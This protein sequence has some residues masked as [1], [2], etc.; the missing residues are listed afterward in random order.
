VTISRGRRGIRIF[1]PDKEQLRENVIR[2]GDQ[3]LALDLVASRVRELL[4][5]RAGNNRWGHW[6]KAWSARAQTLFQH[7]WQTT[8]KP[9][10]QDQVYGQQTT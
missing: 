1:T 6:L 7:I 3:P 4:S 10:V 9:P 2:S 8:K 5:H